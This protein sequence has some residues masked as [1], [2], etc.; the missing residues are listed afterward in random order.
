MEFVSAKKV[1]LVRN[2]TALKINQLALIPKLNLDIV[3]V[4]DFAS[5]GH[6]SAMSLKLASRCVHKTDNV[7]FIIAFMQFLL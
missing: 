6:A 7:S 4:L 3:M 5:V 1:G 2:V